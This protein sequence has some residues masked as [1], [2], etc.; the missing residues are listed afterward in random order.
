[1][2]KLGAFLI[3]VSLVLAACGGQE[4]GETTTPTTPTTIS[5]INVHD[6]WCAGWGYGFASA[7]D[8]E[9]V[10]TALEPLIKVCFLNHPPSTTAFDAFCLGNA[11]G[12]LAYNNDDEAARQ[13]LEDCIATIHD[14]P[15]QQEL[16]STGAELLA[17][18]LDAFIE[19]LV[20]FTSS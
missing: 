8:E 5:A 16:L 18:D 19:S 17:Q 7:G 4:S 1:M 3:A 20:A 13:E 11:S 15:E 12:M 6:A 9:A 10:Q 14:N 2:T